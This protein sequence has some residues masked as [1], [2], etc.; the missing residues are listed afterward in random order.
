M[1]CLPM[2][3]LH[4]SGDSLLR[5]GE[6]FLRRVH[7]D[8]SSLEM[9]CEAARPAADLEDV[10]SVMRITPCSPAPFLHSEECHEVV[11]PVVIIDDALDR[12]DDA[13]PLLLVKLIGVQSTHQL[14]SCVPRPASR[15]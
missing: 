11:H 15:A 9:L 6:Q 1:L 7:T 8:N 10:K 2:L 14:S 3:E 12:P 5:D 13:R 4:I